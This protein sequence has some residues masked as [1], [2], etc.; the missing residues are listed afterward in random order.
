MAGWEL[1]EGRG[2]FLLEHVVRSFDGL[3]DKIKH[4]LF[5]TRARLVK[6]VV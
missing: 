1:T 6:S 2:I 3:N 4:T 5:H